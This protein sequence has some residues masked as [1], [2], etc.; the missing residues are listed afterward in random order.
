LVYRSDFFFWGINELLDTLI[1][2]FIWITI[3]GEKNAIGGFTLS[4]TVTYLIGVG[5]ISNIISSWISYEIE[6]DIKTGQLSNMLTKPIGY[7]KARFSFSLSGKPINLLIRLLV[8]LLIAVFFRSK[9]VVAADF[10]SW[11]F[12]FIS[13]IFAF[14]IHSLFD[15]LV[16]CISFWTITTRGSNNLVRTVDSIFSGN[17]API[18]FF[19]K[20]FQG[21][22]SFLPFMYTRYFPMLIYLGKVSNIEALK[23]MG[24]QLFWIVFLFFSVKLVWKKGVRKFE[25]VGI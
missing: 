8:Y 1:F 11:L 3:Y 2:L 13:I 4:Q 6:S 25:G 9:I 5:L 23:G 22:A 18:A 19:P 15:T 24:I 12:T 20:W 10:F 16:G 17:Y 7:L 14:A 21:V